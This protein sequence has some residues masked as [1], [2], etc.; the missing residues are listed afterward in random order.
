MEL[1][2]ALAGQGRHVVLVGDRH[3]RE[4][5]APIA[6]AL[7]AACTDVTGA[8]PVMETAAWLERCRAFVG[9][10][11]GLMHLAEA[12]GVPVVGLFGPTVREF[13]YYPALQDSRTV[14]RELPCRPCSRNGARPCPREHRVCMDFDADTVGGVLAALLDGSGERR[15]IVE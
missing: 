10:D 11:S 6:Q 14:E 8:T 15:V 7:G 3:D 2:S 13:G 1:A 9:N 5:A 12:L 4:F